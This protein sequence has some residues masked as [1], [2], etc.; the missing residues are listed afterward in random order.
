MNP[1]KELIWSVRNEGDGVL[2]GAANEKKSDLFEDTQRLVKQRK[3][4]A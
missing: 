2:Y 4:E 3:E 1:L